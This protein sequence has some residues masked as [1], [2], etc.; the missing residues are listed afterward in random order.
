VLHQ[1]WT[2]NGGSVVFDV[3]LDRPL[4]ASAFQNVTPVIEKIE[5]LVKSLEPKA[6]AGSAPE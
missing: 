5:A 1:E 3:Q 2:I 6:A 4:P